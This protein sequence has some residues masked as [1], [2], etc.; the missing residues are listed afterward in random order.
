GALPGVAP[1]VA[2]ALRVV[3]FA[4]FRVVGLLLLRESAIAIVPPVQPALRVRA[5]DLVVFLVVA[6]FFAVLRGA[7]FFVAAFFA[8][9]RVLSF[10]LFCSSETKSTT[11]VAAS[12]AGSGSSSTRVVVPLSLIRLR[13]ISARRSRNSSW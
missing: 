3:V 10:R 2:A 13:M 1:D 5:P 9:V 7:D 8:G 4:G 6:F 11:L 12:S